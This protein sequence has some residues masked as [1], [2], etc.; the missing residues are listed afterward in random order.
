MN[1]MKK[2]RCCN[3]EI[4]IAPRLSYSNM[5]GIA[6]NFPD[7]NTLESDAGKEFDI[8][9]CPFCGLIQILQKP[10]YYYKDVIRAVAVSDDMKDFRREYFK[11]FIAQ[12]NLQGKKIIE[13]GAGCGEYM[14]MAAQNDIQIYGLEH[15]EESVLE[16]QKHG[17][18]V[19]KGYIEDADYKIP[20]APYDGF[21]IMNFLEHIPE[22]RIFLA[23]IS[24]NLK[25]DAYGLI[26]VPNAD[27]I[28]KNKMFS[29]FMIDHLSYFTEKSLRLLLE[30]SG[31]EVKSCEVIWKDY[32]IS[33]IVK[34]RNLF[35]ANA[36]I[37]YESDLLSCIN[38]FLKEMNKK[39]RKVAVWGAG[40]QALAIMSLTD[41]KDKIECVIDSAEFKQNKYTPAS[42]IPIYAPDKIKELKIGAVL[43]M[44]GSY[45]DEVAGIL[46]KEYQGIHIAVL[47]D[48][49]LEYLRHEG[50]K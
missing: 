9:Q 10:V 13:I 46:E 1:K 33:A 18:H 15:L 4:E 22:P 27:F 35:D 14:L 12:C 39:G 31:F 28:I 8:Y 2:C 23:G 30:I 49:R 32:I 25:A 5:P 42:H 40:H 11:R 19:F 24:S 47:H 29:E 50:L 17:L 21:Y 44:A 37:E 48:C 45:S 36:F 34:K 7:K 3:N 38:E 6:Q 41:M 26:E 43:V 16:A 20:E